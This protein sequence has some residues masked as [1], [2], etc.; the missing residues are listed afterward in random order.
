MKRIFDIS[1]SVILLTIAFCPFMLLLILHLVCMGRPIFFQQERAGMRGKP[2]NI[3][4][5]RTMRNGAGSDA[6]R[7]TSWGKFLRSTSIDELPELL[8]VLRGEMSIV[9]P[10]PL[11]TR[12]LSRYTSEQQMRHDVLPGIT[13]WAQV[14]G[15]N[16]L[17]WERQ[18]ELDLWY[19]THAS[20]LLDLKILCLTFLT[21]LRRNDINQEGEATR[22]EFRGS[23]TPPQL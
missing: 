2:F 3:L 9:G 16:G 8:N 4:K 6:E 11:P 5:L 23:Q 12:Y 17:S 14:N 22:Q 7:L 10:R 20:F 1:A 13:G 19:V 21:V 18:F 15:R